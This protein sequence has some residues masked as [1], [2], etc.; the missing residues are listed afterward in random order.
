MCYFR[1]QAPATI[2]NLRYFIGFIPLDY[3]YLKCMFHAINN[4]RNQFTRIQTQSWV[5]DI[6]GSWSYKLNLLFIVESTNSKMYCKILAT[7]TMSALDLHL[8]PHIR[9]FR[10]NFAGHE[11]L[12]I[13]RELSHNS[14][15][16]FLAYE[17]LYSRSESP[18]LVP[19][20]GIAHNHIQHYLWGIIQTF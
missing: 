11:Y 4:C 6:K 12:Q 20:I 17:I 19:K 14:R 13:L 2:A 1:I 3:A 9:L 7:L 15:C 10:G 8:T 16:P 5:N 18:F